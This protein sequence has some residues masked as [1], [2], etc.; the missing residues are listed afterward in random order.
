MNG[1]AIQNFHYK[2]L[3]ELDKR[4]TNPDLNRIR[5]ISGT[6][7]IFRSTNGST[8]NSI[9]QGLYSL[10]LCILSLYIYIIL[11][12]LANFEIDEESQKHDLQYQGT[13]EQVR[14]QSYYPT[15]TL[16][17]VVLYVNWTSAP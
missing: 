13:K 17:W 11:Y 15:N 4:R 16:T 6:D 10:S 3:K 2:K 12:V 8:A 9:L 7:D 14:R 5:T 1:E